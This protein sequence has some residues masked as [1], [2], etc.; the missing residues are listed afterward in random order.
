MA[1]PLSTKRNAQ[2]SDE[3]GIQ[4]KVTYPGQ[5]QLSKLLT[6]QKL[7]TSLPGNKPVHDEHLFIVTHQA[8]ELWFKQIIVEIDSIRELLDKE[9]VEISNILTV[10]ER[11]QRIGRIFHVLIGQF[12]VIATMTPQEFLKMR[13]VL[14]NSSGYQS[15]QF[16]L[17]ENKLGVRED[18][19]IK[20]GNQSYED[21]FEGEERELV[22][23]S[24]TE[25]S[26][27]TLIERWLTK[28]AD[29]NKF[30]FFE[31]LKTAVEHMI[32]N[33]EVKAS[34]IDNQVLRKTSLESS[35]KSRTSF[36]SI[37]DRAKHDEL[38]QKGNRR[39]SHKAIEGALMIFHYCKEP[40]FHIPHALLITLIEI[41]QKMA[42]WRHHH[43]TMVQRMIGN[44][45]GTG[46]SSG[47]MYL[48][49]L[50]SDRY[51]VFLDL[52]NMSS[53]FIPEQYLPNPSTL[54]SKI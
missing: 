23:R 19:R 44:L 43:A 6:S 38:V 9:D 18:L 26:L 25:A 35:A 45:E 53:Y 5:L 40:Q 16:R 11:L 41:D 10:N 24:Q 12:D 50:C 39:F 52:V 20:Y 22:I 29:A 8:F 13:H 28:L 49:A 37:L 27:F 15:C 17:I 42:Q 36:D 30:G 1:C 47:Y 14:G 7:L 2:E 34:K 54:E 21:A 31:K 4:T 33:D 51:K 3:E 32:T 48:R 46:G